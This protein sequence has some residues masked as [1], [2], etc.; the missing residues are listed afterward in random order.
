VIFF[1]KIV[2]EHGG[3]TRPR[4]SWTRC[5]SAGQPSKQADEGTR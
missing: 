4:K 2:R 3:R 5:P 1:S